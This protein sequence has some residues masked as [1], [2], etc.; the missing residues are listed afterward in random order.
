MDLE[1]TAPFLWCVLY[2][3][4]ALLASLLQR[5]QFTKKEEQMLKMS[6]AKAE[7]KLSFF[8]L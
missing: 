8:Q 1:L 4:I 5:V 6:N 2:L 3:Q 7:I